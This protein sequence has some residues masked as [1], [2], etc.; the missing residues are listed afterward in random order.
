MRIFIQAIIATSLLSLSAFANDDDH[1][2][3]Y[4]TD[5]EIG[6]RVIGEG[7]HVCWS[8]DYSQQ[9]K[10]LGRGE[11]PEAAEENAQYGA[12]LLAGKAGELSRSS[13]GRCA[14]SLSPTG[15]IVMQDQGPHVSIDVEGPVR[16]ECVGIS[17]IAGKPYVASASTKIEAMAL[18][19]SAAAASNDNDGTYVSLKCA[20]I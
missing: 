16:F 11:T 2:I 13:H 18:A 1:G 5:G 4:V 6:F 7:E 15:V 14:K 8:E 9:I 20:E 19:E 3:V 12:S 17:G 10:V